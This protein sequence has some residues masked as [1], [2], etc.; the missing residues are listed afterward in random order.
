M[1]FGIELSFIRLHLV[2]VLKAIG[3]CGN[4]VIIYLVDDGLSGQAVRPEIQGS[5]FIVHSCDCRNIHIFH[6]LVF[7]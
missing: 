7:T 1:R 5:G 6:V 3:Y 2:I 4:D